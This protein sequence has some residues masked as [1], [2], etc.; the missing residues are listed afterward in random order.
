[1]ELTCI[2][3]LML[4]CCLFLIS[5]TAVFAKQAW[6]ITPTE[7]N[8]SFMAT[9]NDVL[10]PGEFKSFT[11][12][13]DFDPANLQSSSIHIIVNMDSIASS[14]P[15]IADT[16]KLPEWFNVGL[17]P[18]ADFESHT[19]KKMDDKSYQA[20][21]TLAMRDKTMPVSLSFTLDE[22]SSTLAHVRGKTILKRTAFGIG[23]GDWEKTDQVK[24]NVEV[25]F[26]ITA[27]R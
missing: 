14:A 17:F 6:I 10:V 22:Y 12:S 27:H 5:T 9:Q 2:R 16:L 26:T 7:S 19:I 11:G 20:D 8:I 1:M 23:Q 3:N 15:T 13:I 18:Q 25:N 21:G 24:D 4:I